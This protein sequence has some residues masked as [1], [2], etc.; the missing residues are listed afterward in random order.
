VREGLSGFSCISGSTKQRDKQNKPD[1]PE[2]C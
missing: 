2:S 1:E